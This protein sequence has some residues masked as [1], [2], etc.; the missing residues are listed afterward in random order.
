MSKSAKLCDAH[1][2]TSHKNVR[3]CRH[4]RRNFCSVHLVCFVPGEKYLS[5]DGE[6]LT[7]V[8][9]HPCPDYYDYLAA[10]K[11]NEL[12]EW[13]SVLDV[14]KQTGTP[15][16]FRKKF[17]ATKSDISFRNYHQ[18]CQRLDCECAVDLSRCNYCKELF[19]PT[20]LSPRRAG[21]LDFR[22]TGHETRTR[23]NELRQAGGHP[24]T[25]YTKTLP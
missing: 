7:G 16:G 22:G 15:K 24:C 4:C 10:K 25:E 11:E 12:D 3:V 18:L 1:S 23:N 14:L 6:N 21:M 20:H 2:C 13:G 9:G 17:D 8:A 5:K 19:C